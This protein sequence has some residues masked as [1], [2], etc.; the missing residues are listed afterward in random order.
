MLF[1]LEKINNS[2]ALLRNISLGTKI[3]DTC[4]SQ[5]IGADRARELIK[6]TLMDQSSPLAGVIGPFVSDVSIAVAN[7]LRVFN[8]PQISYG[9]TSPDLSNK[10]LYSYFFRTVPPDSFQAQAL[11]D[12]VKKYGWNYIFTVHSSGNYGQKGIAKFHEA[13]KRE[14]ICIALAEKIPHLATKKDFL[15]VI[16]KFLRDEFTKVNVIVMFTTQADG[17]GLLHA[18]TEAKALHF[19]WVGNNA[20]STRVDV[21]IGNEAV[22]DGAITI[23]HLQGT[24]TGFEEYLRGL[25]HQN[26]DYNPWFDEYL[27]ALKQCYW[28]VNELRSDCSGDGVLPHYIELAPVRVVMNAVYAMAHALDRLQKHLCPSSTGMCHEMKENF[29]RAHFLE[30]LRNVSYPDSA[31][32]FEV[33]FNQNQE[34]DGNYSVMNFHKNKNGSW[35]YFS[36]GSWG[37]KV[38]EDGKIKGSLHIND[39]DLEWGKSLVA[40]PLSICSE[41]CNATQIRRR[42]H[43]NPECCWGCEHCQKNEFIANGQCQRCGKGFTPNKNLSA[44]FKIPFSFPKWKDASSIAFTVLSSLGILATLGTAALFIKH[45]N[46]SIIKAA[47]RELSCILFTGIALCYLAIFSYLAKPSSII[48]S[49]RRVIGT[50]CFTTCYVPVL[51]KTN[52]IY[53]IFRSAQRTAARP[54]MISP[55]SQVLISLGL[56]FVQLLLTTIWLFSE[57]PCTREVYS[58]YEATILECSENDY[59]LA[60]NLSYN[61]LLML[62]CTVFAFKTRNFPRNFNE[63]K[64]IGISMYLTCSVWVIFFPSYLNTSD[65]FWRVYFF[66]S[67]FFLIGTITLFGLLFPKICI[68]H[69][70]GARG[71]RIN[72]VTMDTTHAPIGKIHNEPFIL[73]PILEN[74]TAVHLQDDSRQMTP[75]T[76]LQTAVKEFGM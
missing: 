67:A 19:T 17:T 11:V 62:L 22:A 5:T 7:L 48:C 25:N 66:C 16:T 37:G 51:M 45:R 20:W 73:H 15:A 29:Q 28:K 23:S 1:A 3:Y 41:P 24:V 26:N 69:F 72:D 8:I 50:I 13:A 35:S 34:M 59:S 46:N 54:S 38:R 12:I 43:S 71:T 60:V 53:R 31:L 76:S 32:N 9:S 56:I 40:R 55:R 21:T 10:E 68:L 64:Y 63:A 74:P 49:V 57:T 36:V 42:K 30:Y 2:T 27:Q 70:T 75:M 14:G 44:C 47:G 39:V 52:R 61:L 58:S 6:H 4:R 18:A 33:R 65:T